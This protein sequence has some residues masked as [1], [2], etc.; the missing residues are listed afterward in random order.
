VFTSNGSPKF[1][2]SALNSDYPGV[3]TDLGN[4]STSGGQIIDGWNSMTVFMIF[5]WLDTSNWE[6]LLWK[7]NPNGGH[8]IKI[9]KMNVGANQGTGCYFPRHADNG[10]GQDRVYNSKT[11]ARSSTKILTLT[12]DGAS[13]TV[14]L[15]GNG[16]S[17]STKTN[18]KNDLGSS[19]GSAINLGND[20][21]YGD[22]LIYRNSLSNADREHIEGFL[23]LKYGMVN[24]LPATHSGKP[25]DGWLL[26]A[27]IGND[28][29]ANLDEVGNLKSG[30]LRL[31]LR[32]RIMP[33]TM[34]FPLMT[35]EPGNFISMGQ[36]LALG[37]QREIFL[38]PEHPWFSVLLI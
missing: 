11:D 6:D 19:T 2:G 14:K 4:F 1:E 9:R 37:K 8:G 16:V 30:A 38:P 21:R 32:P 28:L 29:A 22:I 25:V 12:Y 34:W 17:A 35:V 3:N 33:G 31:Y 36:R 27:G 20:Q 7:G 23:A 10:G 13:K 18:A 24:Q 15:Y 26:G 5:D